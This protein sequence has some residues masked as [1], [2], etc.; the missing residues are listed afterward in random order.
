MSFLD[1]HG[2]RR[3]DLFKIDLIL[4]DRVRVRAR[5]Y[6]RRVLGRLVRGRNGSGLVLFDLPRQ[7]VDPFHSLRRPDLARRPIDLDQ[8]E[9]WVSKPRE[10]CKIPLSGIIYTL[11]GQWLT[12]S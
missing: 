6:D 11:F 1:L 8:E 7:P 5:G 2:R 9:V 3:V 4:Q 12:C 10:N